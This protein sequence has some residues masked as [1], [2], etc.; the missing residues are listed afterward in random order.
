[1][2]ETIKGRITYTVPESFFNAGDLGYLRDIYLNIHQTKVFRE[3]MGGN[4]GI[5]SN[6]SS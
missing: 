6:I 2:N 1:M 4:K 3:L 5:H